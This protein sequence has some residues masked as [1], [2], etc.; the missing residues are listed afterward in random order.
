MAEQYLNGAQVCAG[1]KQMSGEAVPQG[2]RMQR[3]LNIGALGGLAAGVP[4][5]FFVNG[6]VGRMPL[7]AGGGEQASLWFTTETT[8]VLPQCGQQVRAEHDIA[9]F[10]SLAS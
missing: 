8:I 9:I 4:D 7:A 6:I 10:A 1:L 2:M 3:F 5:D